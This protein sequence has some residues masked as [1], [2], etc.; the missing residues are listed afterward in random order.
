M[1]FALLVCK[2]ATA[3]CKLFHALKIPIQGGI[4]N[5]GNNFTMCELYSYSAIVPSSH[6]LT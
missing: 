1:M 5:T 3:G 2:K 6:L 4:P